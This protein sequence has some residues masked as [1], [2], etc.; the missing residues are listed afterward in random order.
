MS[1]S[2]FYRKLYEN[3]NVVCLLLKRRS[4]FVFGVKK[5][6]CLNSY[7]EAFANI[8][9]FLQKDIMIGISN[10]EE[11]VAFHPGFQL[12]ANIKKGDKVPENDPLERAMNS[13]ETVQ[14]IIPKEVYGIAFKAISSPIKN[15]AGEIIGGVGIGISLE[16]EFEMSET[17]KSLVNTMTTASDNMESVNYDVEN[18]S[19]R[20]QDNSAAIEQSLAGIQ[21]MSSNSKVIH[22]I[23][24]ETKE[25]SQNVKQEAVKGSESVKNIVTSVNG[26]SDA[27]NNI[28]KLIS[29]LNNSINRIGEIVNL[30]NDISEQTNL[31]ALNAAIE[32]A[33]AGDQG[34]GFAVVAEE[35]RKLA[36]QS[37]EATVDISEL[38]SGIQVENQNVIKAVKNNE[39]KINEGVRATEDTSKNILSILNSIELVDDKINNISGRTN[40]QS[41]ISEQIATA[42]ESIAGSVNDT[43]DNANR[44]SSVVHEQ[45]GEIKGTAQKV[46]VLA[47]NLIK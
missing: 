42:I 4:G 33:R 23:S 18:I 35:V 39:E 16:E 46:T 11:F 27:S 43:A 10:R 29:E 26:I 1:K 31:L 14:D 44:I 47:D 34:R 37:K 32:A 20:V 41:D 24:S 6:K 8:K 12:T 38:V 2:E 5:K 25:L 9:E 13:G 36:E 15:A 17:L 30:I 28:F 7:V 40:V 3:I 19:S 21:E 45:M 22:Q